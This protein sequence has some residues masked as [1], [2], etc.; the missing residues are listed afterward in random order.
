MP[1]PFGGSNKM[2]KRRTSGNFR[3]AVG[4]CVDEACRYS[5]WGKPRRK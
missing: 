1:K 4:R 2:T 3:I 5:P